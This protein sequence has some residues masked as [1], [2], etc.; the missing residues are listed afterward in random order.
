MMEEIELTDF[1]RLGVVKTKIIDSSWLE[2]SLCDGFCEAP[3]ICPLL[4]DE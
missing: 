4:P 1:C 2:S 3:P